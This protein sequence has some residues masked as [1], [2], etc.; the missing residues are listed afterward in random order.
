LRIANRTQARAEALAQQIGGT[1]IPFE[2]LSVGL[3]GA[4]LLLACATATTPLVSR[5]MLE[6]AMIDREGKPLLVLDIAV[7]RDIE[8]GAR[9]VSG[10]SLYDMDDIN[11]ICEQN[12]HARL[13]SARAA[14][15]H[16]AD[17]TERFITWQQERKAAPMIQRLR[18]DAERL[19]AAEVERTLKS[20]PDLNDSR[21]V[22]IEAMSRRLTQKLLHQPTVWLREHAE[23]V[24][25]PDH[26]P[27]W[28]DEEQL[29]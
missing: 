14:E 10:V 21:R 16:I 8:S 2:L 19:R 26:G 12:R 18:N 17:W 25:R 6:Q 1:A 27:A 29:S 22:T 24:Q 13:A 4:D 3:A 15:R 9:D 23:D 11:H 5:A 20:F 28:S 7:P